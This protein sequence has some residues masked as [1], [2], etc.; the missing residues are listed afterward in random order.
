VRR[1]DELNA[2]RQYRKIAGRQVSSRHGTIGLARRSGGGGGGGGGAR[3][4]LI[5]RGTRV[6]IGAL[7]RGSDGRRAAVRHIAHSPRA[8]RRPVHVNNTCLSLRL[9]TIVTASAVRGAPHVKQSV[10]RAKLSTPHYRHTPT[11]QKTNDN[12]QIILIGIKQQYVQRC[13]ANRRGERRRCSA[14]Q[15]AR[16]RAARRCRRWRGMQP[17]HLDY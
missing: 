14:A 7:R 3:G 12:L 15:C 10:R 11:K 16:R 9:L 1:S 8:T 5:G 17:P 13:I 2:R 4:L 6:A